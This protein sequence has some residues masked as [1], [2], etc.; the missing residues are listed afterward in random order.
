V[1]N[2]NAF[3]IVQKKTQATQWAKYANWAAYALMFVGGLNAATG[4]FQFLTAD[5]I[6]VPYMTPEGQTEVLI[7]IPTGEVAKFGFIKLVGGLLL[8]MQG[9]F[10]HKMAEMGLKNFRNFE[11]GAQ[12]PA[13]YEKLSEKNKA[14][15]SKIKKIILAQFVLLIIT[16]IAYHMLARHLIPQAA[17]QIQIAN[18]SAYRSENP[19][20]QYPEGELRADFEP[21]GPK[22]HHKDHEGKHH[23]G[24]HHEGE[25][26][27]EHKH[28]LRTPEERLLSQWVNGVMAMCFAVSVC[29][30][31]ICCFGCFKI[32]D[33]YAKYEKQAECMITYSQGQHFQPVPFAAQAP[34]IDQER[35]DSAYSMGMAIN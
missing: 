8:F 6:T 4:A 18:E 24:K 32:V 21:E 1:I 16:F 12:D 28:H 35:Q 29:C 25:H 13:A 11:I 19:F 20:E 17:R 23:E 10:G 2:H 26:H 34:E 15:I 3:A 31:G 27:G 14:F 7:D 22:G 30:F 5:E 9:Y 33:T